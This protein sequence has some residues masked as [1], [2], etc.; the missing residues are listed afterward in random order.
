MNAS[1][2][3]IAKVEGITQAL[4]ERIKDCLDNSL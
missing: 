4:A 1:V 2:D 3:D